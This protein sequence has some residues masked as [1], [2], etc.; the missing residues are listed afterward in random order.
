MESYTGLG[1][2]LPLA[3]Q[4][5]D[6]SLGLSESESESEAVANM[7]TPAQNDAA[8]EALTKMMGGVSVR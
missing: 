6:E 1:L 5:V 2:S 4:R 3:V 8:L 7:V